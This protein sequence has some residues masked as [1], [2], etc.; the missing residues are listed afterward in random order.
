MID[1]YSD[2]KTRPTAAMREAIAKAEVGDEQHGE[3]PTVERLTTR[4]AAL[5]GKPAAVYLPSGTMAN[6]IAVLLHCRAGDEVIAHEHSH[7]LNFEAGGVAGLAGAMVRTIGGER[8]MFTAAALK[9]A[10]RPKARHL[11]RSRLVSVEQTTNLGGGAV[12]EMALM[13]EVTAVARDA[14]LATHLDGARLM[15]AVVAAGVPA[16]RFAAGFDTAFLDFTKGLGAPF[17]AV[18]AGSAALIEEAWRWKQRMGG[19][20]RQAGMMAAAC[21]HALDHHVDRLQ[22]DHANARRLAQALALIPGLRVEPVQTNMV[23]CDVSALGLS[24]AEFNQR[25]RPHGVRMS[26][27][28]PSRLRAVTHLDVSAADIDAVAAA[29]AAVASGT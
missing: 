19:S 26:T 7:L 14:G 1:L 29:A 28:G 5:L 18:L 15:N 3:D 6:E 27:Q 21:L 2:T 10:L 22:D 24:A 13:D 11:P 12:W 4:S 16:D 23:F 20:M 8:G 17:G 9:A 25:L